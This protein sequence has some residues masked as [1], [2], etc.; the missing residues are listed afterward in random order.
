MPVSGRL[1][2]KTA[3][4]FE[5]A[6]SD[7]MRAVTTRAENIRLNAIAPSSTKTAFVTGQVVDVTGGQT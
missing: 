6:R 2:G 7:I 3:I 5:A 1:A 4:T